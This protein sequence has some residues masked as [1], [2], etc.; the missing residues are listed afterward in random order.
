MYGCES[1]IMKK[2]ERQRIDAFKLWCWRRLLRFLCTAKRSNQSILK[3]INPKYLLEGLMLMMRLQYFSHLIQR[4]NS[5]EETLMPE[6]IEGKRRWGDR[7]WDVW[8]ASPTQGTWVWASPG[9]WW[10]TG[11]PGVLQ[12]MGLQRVR[13]DWVTEL[14]WSTSNA[15]YKGNSLDLFIWKRLSEM[16]P[17]YNWRQQ[18]QP[19]SG[20]SRASS[21]L[22]GQGRRTRLWWLAASHCQSHRPILTETIIL[23]I[24]GWQTS[25]QPVNDS[26]TW[27][28][29]AMCLSRLGALYT[30]KRSFHSLFHLICLINFLMW[31][32]F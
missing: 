23:S 24:K 8:M 7:R 29:W 28:R 2:A 11:K 17:N 26:V 4:A 6:K 12:S 31:T 9:N 27:T 15:P 30:P 5:L 16:K 19:A 21:P 3:E 1:W 32:S 22:C 18:G 14:N 10:W 25:R 20:E 13:Q